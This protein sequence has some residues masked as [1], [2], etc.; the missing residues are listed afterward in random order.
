V[1]HLLE[2]NLRIIVRRSLQARFGAP[3]HRPAPVPDAC[4]LPS[5][6]ANRPPNQRPA[7]PLP[8][9]PIQQA[10]AT[11]PSSPA[12]ASAPVQPRP[13]ARP[14]SLQNWSGRSSGARAVT[15]YNKHFLRFL[16][17]TQPVFRPLSAWPSLP[18]SIE[19]Q[20]HIKIDPHYLWPPGRFG[21]QPRRAP[22]SADAAAFGSRIW[23]PVAGIIY[24]R[25]GIG[26]AVPAS[27]VKQ[28]RCGGN[29]WTYANGFF[30]APPEE[31]CKWPA[32]SPLL[33]SVQGPVNARGNNVLKK[34][35]SDALL[36]QHSSRPLHWRRSHRMASALVKAPVPAC[37]SCA[38]RRRGLVRIPHADLPW[39]STRGECIDPTC[40]V[41]LHRLV[42]TP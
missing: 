17:G 24:I 37:T 26:S 30:L 7:L 4:Q 8:P 9:P 2:A 16:V 35:K 29:A 10:P 19:A 3:S 11:L 5:A 21:L 25:L 38:T 13:A 12:P 6:Q 32:G 14:I 39:L 23:K 31:P 18:I 27:V 41:T 40:T 20:R 36:T 28:V 22:V 42:S 15:R 33:S 1:G 34:N